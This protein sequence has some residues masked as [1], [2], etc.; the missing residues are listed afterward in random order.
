M[1]TI[2]SAFVD[3]A[4]VGIDSMIRL[5]FVTSASDMQSFATWPNQ[6]DI[7]NTSI[8]IQDSDLNVGAIYAGMRVIAPPGVTN[9]LPQFAPPYDVIAPNPM[10]PIGDFTIAPPQTSFN[11]RSYYVADSSIWDPHMLDHVC[12]Y[13]EYDPAC[14]LYAVLNSRISNGPISYGDLRQITIDSLDN[15]LFD[16]GHGVTIETTTPLLLS[17]P[18]AF[19]LL[20]DRFAAAV[21][22]NPT[23]QR[24][25]LLGELLAYDGKFIGGSTGNELNSPNVQDMW[26]L[27]NTWVANVMLAI[28]G[29]VIPSVVSPG[30]LPWSSYFFFLS[31]LIRLLANPCENPI[32]YTGYPGYND[33]AT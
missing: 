23:P 15:K 2:R 14:W 26:F 4:M 33:P 10:P 9:N 31:F 18:N 25:S 3:N 24:I 11:E 30:P 8:L 27:S 19:F 21:L 29:P 5:N 12:G 7:V 20:K 32:F 13:Y 16:S 1:L 6:T 28:L 22:A 17:S